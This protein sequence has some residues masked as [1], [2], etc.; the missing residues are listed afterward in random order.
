MDFVIK[1]VGAVS[2]A[3]ALGGVVW[4]L[5]R[6]K[7]TG[8]FATLTS[9][10]GKRRIKFVQNWGSLLGLVSGLGAMAAYFYFEN[11]PNHEGIAD[12]R[13]NF[14]RL[15]LAKAVLTPPRIPE[16]PAVWAKP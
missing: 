7:A 11:Q 15:T 5:D 8:W 3:L 14:A 6:G 4:L 13:S 2:L 16:H 12:A 9:Y 10:A 1:V